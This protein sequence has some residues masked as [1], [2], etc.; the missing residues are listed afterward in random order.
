MNAKTKVS[1]GIGAIGK[2]MVYAF[3][4]GFLMYY[5]NTVL[6][7]SATFIGILFMAARVFDALNDPMMGVVVEKTRTPMGKFRHGC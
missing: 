2:D 1:Y 5:F 4:S 6:G 3:V 7:I